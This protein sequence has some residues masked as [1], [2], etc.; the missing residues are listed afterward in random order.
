MR[1][2][3]T[4]WLLL[5][6]LL[7]LGLGLG[8]AA[9]AGEEPAYWALAF[10]NDTPKQLVLEDAAAGKLR[11]YW[12]V[13]YRVKNPEQKPLPARLRLALK[14]SIGNQVKD[15]DDGFDNVAEM[16]VEKKVLERPV[17]NW[18]EMRAQPLK[19]GESREGIAIFSLGNE[20]PDFD[21]M[22]VYVRGLA[23]LRPLGREGNVRKARERT[24]LLRYEQVASRWRS[25]KELKYLPEE[26]TLEEVAVTDRGEGEDEAAKKAGQKLQELIE[27]AKKEAERRKKLDAEGAKPPP[28]KSSAGPPKTPI[29]AGPPA[30]QPAPDLVNTLRKIAAGTPTVRATL[31][32]AIGQGERRQEATG[33]LCVGKDGKFTIERNSQPGTEQAL[34]EQRVFDSQH[35]WIQTVAK[36]VGATVRRWTVAATKKEWYTLDGKPEVDF[37][38][39][40]NPARAWRLFADDL[41]Y[42]GTERLGRETAYVFEV[43]PDKKHEALLSGPLVCDVLAKAPGRRIR[44][45]LGSVTGFQLKM[46]VRD[47]RGGVVAALECTDLSVDAPVPPDAFVF[48]P[49]AGVEVIDMNAAF[50]AGDKP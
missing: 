18:A 6:V 27:K 30:G 2:P 48:K 11:F 38:A 49:P 50:A 44:F 20:A 37:A 23:E 34:K 28:G 1:T 41:L 17:C 26:W 45:W 40:A 5:A 19:P 42:L 35:L 36:G 32:E 14:L 31:A 21:K 10:E 13:V 39:V 43:C 4:R 16:H 47:D 7:L 46:Q 24:L 33:T 29:A 9:R 8:V 15:Y 22:T 3:A 25:G 12:Y